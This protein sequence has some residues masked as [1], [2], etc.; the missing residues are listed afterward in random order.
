MLHKIGVF[1]THNWSLKMFHKHWSTGFKSRTFVLDKGGGGT[2]NNKKRT[3]FKLVQYNI[4]KIKLLGICRKTVPWINLKYANNFVYE[5][6]LLWPL[7][8][9]CIFSSISNILIYH[10]FITYLHRSIHFPF[11]WHKAKI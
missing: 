7:N 4:V 10:N 8:K 9:H 3:I 6:I 11:L 5:Y 1:N 2:W